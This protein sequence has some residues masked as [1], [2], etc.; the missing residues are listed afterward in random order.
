M[1]KKAVIM[2]ILVLTLLF[3]GCSNTLDRASFCEAKGYY[4]NE[5]FKNWE[6]ESR[7]FNDFNFYCVDLENHKISGLYNSDGELLDENDYCMLVC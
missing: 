3:S 1:N 2:L 7:E 4:K 6:W 5:A